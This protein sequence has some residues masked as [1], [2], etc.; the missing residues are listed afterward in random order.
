MADDVSTNSSMR[1]ESANGRLWRSSESSLPGLV[2]E[3]NGRGPPPPLQRRKSFFHEETDDHVKSLSNPTSFCKTSTIHGLRFWPQ[4][5]HQPKLW[6][7]VRICW[8]LLTLASFGVVIFFTYDACKKYLEYKT[9]THYAVKRT[10][11]LPFPA[12]TVCNFNPLRYYAV[13]QG[14]SSVNITDLPYFYLLCS[15]Y[16]L[17]RETFPECYSEAT[18]NMTKADNRS[19]SEI[20]EF[21]GHQKRSMIPNVG[22]P[23]WYQSSCLY[24]SGACSSANFS[25][26]HTEYGNCY[27]FNGDPDSKLK[28]YAHGQKSGLEVLLNVEQQEY[29]SRG[30]TAVG[31]AIYIHP[32]HRPVLA[33][34][35]ALALTPGTDNFVALRAIRVSGQS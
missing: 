35:G 16:Q 3:R 15:F 21:F 23:A 18:I 33:Y 4:Y 2:R 1:M 19:L 9:T 29:F 27:T 17:D 6:I 24:A 7:I 14:A 28:A 13:L 26:I 22:P 20:Y 32:P 12:V 25:L 5:P 34:H 31:A 8:V 30:V 10:T 11:N